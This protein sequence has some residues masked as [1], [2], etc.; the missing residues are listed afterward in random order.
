MHIASL[1]RLDLSEKEIQIFQKQ[2]SGI[3]QY[4]DKLKV[5]DVEQTDPTSHIH[6][7]HNVL[8]EDTCE[9]SIDVK[10]ALANTPDRSD[11]FYKVPKI[12]E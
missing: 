1:A 11:A 3:I 6:A 9:R 2:L 4:V 10:E 12:I 7:T 8:R 5:V